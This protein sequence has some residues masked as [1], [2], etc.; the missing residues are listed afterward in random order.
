MVDFTFPIPYKTGAVTLSLSHIISNVNLGRIPYDY[1][2][3]ENGRVVYDGDPQ[4]IFVDNT[5][6]RTVGNPSIRIEP[7]I[8]GVDANSARE[9]DGTWRPIRPGDRVL[10]KVWIKTGTCSPPSDLNNGGRL[11]MDCYGHG[12]IGG[13]RKFGVVLKTANADSAEGLPGWYWQNAQYALNGIWKA[14]WNQ[15][16]TLCGWD[17]TIPTELYPYIWSGSGPTLCDTPV[18]IDYIVPWLDVRPVNICVAWFADAELYIN[19]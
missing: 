4:I 9:C 15:N 13:V 11:G 12:M 10:I 14:E 3:Y 2:E 8:A 16:W 1:G 18:A 19:P 5:V 17:Y 6:F 7:H